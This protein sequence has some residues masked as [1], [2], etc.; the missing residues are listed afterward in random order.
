MLNFGLLHQLI[1][2]I[3]SQNEIN[4]LG[5]MFLTFLS[6]KPLFPIR[7]ALASILVYLI[8]LKPIYRDFTVVVT[9]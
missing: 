8:K 9:K 5:I 7:V 2:L 3:W 1:C 6:H 4:Y